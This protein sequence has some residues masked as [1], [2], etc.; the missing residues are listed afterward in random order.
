MR[1]M[2]FEEFCQ[3]Q[4]DLVADARDAGLSIENIVITL[5]GIANGLDPKLFAELAATKID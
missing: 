4:A 5:A 3:K 2:T 1:A